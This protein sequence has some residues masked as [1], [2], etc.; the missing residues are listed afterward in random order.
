MCFGQAV[1]DIV[2][3]VETYVDGYGPGV[4]SSVGTQGATRQHHEL[5]DRQRLR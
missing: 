3:G 5:A 1:T 4:G 2:G